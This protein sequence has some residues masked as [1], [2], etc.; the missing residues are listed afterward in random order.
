MASTNIRK[1][2]NARM[3]TN[4][5]ELPNSEQTGMTSIATKPTGFAV[6]CAFVADMH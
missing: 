1:E 3:S 4:G 2:E 6:F 5:R